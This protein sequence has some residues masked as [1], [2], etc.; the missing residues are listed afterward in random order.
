[1]YAQY[2][3][4]AS[5]GQQG[6][7]TRSQILESD[8]QIGLG[9]WPH[10]ILVVRFFFHPIISKLDSSSGPHTYTNIKNG[11]TAPLQ[12]NLSIMWPAHLK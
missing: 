7:H 6:I 9:I 8:N 1:M 10:P 4:G 5:H 2:S 11:S 12:K 3:D